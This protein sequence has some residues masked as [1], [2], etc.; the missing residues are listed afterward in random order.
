MKANFQKAAATCFTFRKGQMAKQ[1]S[2]SWSNLWLEGLQHNNHDDN[3]KQW[4]G[5]GEGGDNNNGGAASHIKHKWLLVHPFFYISI[6]FIQVLTKVSYVYRYILLLLMTHDEQWTRPKT[7]CLTCLGYGNWDCQA[8]E[9]FAKHV[10]EG[11]ADSC[12]C[13]Q[14]FPR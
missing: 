6:S 2:L 10:V 1:F 13:N 7:C 3:A 4:Q 8:S 11:D 14:I 5:Q 9:G 12:C